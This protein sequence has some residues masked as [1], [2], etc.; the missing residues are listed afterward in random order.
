MCDVASRGVAEESNFLRPRGGRLF[1]NQ[2]KKE[3]E[4]GVSG[5]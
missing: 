5:K 3:R 2:Q 1:E 4:I